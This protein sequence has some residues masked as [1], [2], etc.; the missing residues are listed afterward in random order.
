MEFCGI[1]LHS[2][3]CVVVI[4]DEMDKVLELVGWADAGSPTSSG[5]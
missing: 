2:N 1:D 3:N 4:T 5:R